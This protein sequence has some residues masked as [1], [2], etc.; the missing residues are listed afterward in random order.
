MAV[1]IRLRRIGRKKQPHYRIVVADAASPREGR[2]IETVGY[3]QPLS[4]PARVVVNH[5][6]VQ[7]WLERGATVSTTVHS[8]LKKAKK[9]GDRAVAVGPPVPRE[10]TVAREPARG[11]ARAAAAPVAGGGEAA[12]EAGGEAG[13]QAGAAAPHAA[14]PGA[15]RAEKGS[16]GE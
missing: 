9:G 1:R 3:Y 8:L 10:R 4:Q 13:A 7:Y 2:V 14:E 11:R 6:R 16:A 15:E 12:S 5:E